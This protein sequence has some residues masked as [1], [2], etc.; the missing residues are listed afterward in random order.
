MLLVLYS[1]ASVNNRINNTII[2]VFFSLRFETS[3]TTM[4]FCLYE[5]SLNIEVQDNL[6]QEIRTNLIK[7]KNQL[8][9]ESMLEMKYLQMV[10][11]GENLSFCLA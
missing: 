1:G 6:R 11:D 3:S 7:N 4:T 10:I 8:T 9:Y 2:I 5:L